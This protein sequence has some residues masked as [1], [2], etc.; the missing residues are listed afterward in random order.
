MVYVSV[1]TRLQL[2]PRETLGDSTCK[3]L[4]ASLGKLMMPE[5]TDEWKLPATPSGY[6]TGY[7]SSSSLKLGCGGGI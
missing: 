4:C 6:A 7:S 1:S 5:V 2:D 3:A